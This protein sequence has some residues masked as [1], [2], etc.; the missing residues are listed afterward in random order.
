MPEFEEITQSLLAPELDIFG[1]ERDPMYVGQ[2]MLPNR[3]TNA[4]AHLAAVEGKK[5]RLLTCESDGRLDVYDS[6]VYN[7]LGDPLSVRILDHDGTIG[8]AV[9]DDYNLHVNLWYKGS[10][11]SGVKE[12]LDA[13]NSWG[14][15]VW[16][17]DTYR[18]YTILSDVHDSVN[19]CLR[20]CTI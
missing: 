19:H 7:R 10:R 13:Y 11:L 1:V 17:Y 2:Y 16:N 18:V 6:S 8:V 15:V 20:V 9:D 4:I 5:S 14:L 3:L 12:G